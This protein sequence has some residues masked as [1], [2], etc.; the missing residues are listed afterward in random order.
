MIE[1]TDD[2]RAEMLVLAALTYRG[3]ADL[4]RGELHEAAVRQQIADGLGRLPLVSGRWDL[5]WGPVTS[6]SGDRFDSTATFVV[7]RRS[8]S[9]GYVVAVRGTNPLSI[10][11][12]LFGDFLVNPLV[13]WPFTGDGSAISTSTAFG[14]RT[15]LRLASSP[16]GP[17]EQVFALARE[18]TH[19]ATAAA[20]GIFRT[21]DHGELR[22]RLL[23]SLEDQLTRAIADF[24][25]VQNLPGRVE[26]RLSSTV[27]VQSSELRPVIRPP[28]DRAEGQT[29]LE[30]FAAET[31]TRGSIDIVVTG[32]S[33]GGALAPALALYL[34]ETRISRGG[35]P[36]W[37]PSGTSTIGCVTFAGPTPGNGAFARRVDQEL[38]SAHQRIANTNDV[39]THAWETHQLEAIAG[40]FD[41]RSAPLQ[42]L[43]ATVAAATRPFDYQHASTGFLGFPGEIQSGS[44]GAELI[45]QHLN[46]YLERF[47]L[48]KRGI[49]ALSLFVG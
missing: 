3:F 12:W 36:G 17:I 48:L 41:R 22:L 15:I 45:H 44:L 14:L 29:L 5:V 42:K 21:L 1:D 10:S 38:G 31:S 43:L 20:E 33:K 2:A 26:Q 25:A 8:T 7:K 27:T 32:H 13:T 47:G 6:R 4:L 19:R 28:T 24:A 37:D 40:L 39:V 9:G 46:A 18:A 34:K 23:P 49:D 30:F 11:D 16:G 35:D